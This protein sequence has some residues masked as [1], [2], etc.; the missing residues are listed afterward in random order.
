MSKYD[1]LGAFLKSRPASEIPMTFA[2][3]EAVIGTKLP[4]SAHRHRPWWSN[5]ATN[6]A[7]TKVW[8]DAG[9]L[10]AQVD[11]EGRKL[12]FKRMKTPPSPSANMGMADAAR[13]FEPAQAGEK[14]SRRSPLFGALKGTFT[15]DPGW[16]LTQPTMS[17]EDLDDMEANL[18]R[19]A[20]LIDAGFARKPR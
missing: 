16:D 13:A 1:L 19:T 10:A 2:E 6:S 17:P 11:M 4:G 5:N 7:M 15:I 8:L 20:D 3:I 14:K 18:Q 12:V 9:F